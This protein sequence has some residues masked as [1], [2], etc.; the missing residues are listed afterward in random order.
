MNI[1]DALTRDSDA[2]QNINFELG[3]HSTGFVGVVR[4]QFRK[5]ES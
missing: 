3:V 2:L 1:T 5:A 4:F